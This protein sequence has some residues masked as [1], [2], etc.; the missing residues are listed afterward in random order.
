VLERGVPKQVDP[1]QRRLLV[2]DA[3]LD[4]ILE[5]GIHSVTLARIAERTGLAVGSI[6][7]FF[8]GFDEVL[9]FTFAVL[10]TRMRERAADVGPAGA[11]GSADPL[12]TVGALLLRSAPGQ[13]PHREN[14]AYLEYLTRARTIPQLRAEIARTQAASEEVVG[15]LL[16][17]A[18]AGTAA[19]EADVR[20]ETAAVSALLNGLALTDAHAAEPLDPA[21]VREIVSRTLDRLRRAYPLLGP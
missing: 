21:D 4:E 14:V 6:R 19:T 1:E 20:L 18:L 17:A 2:A 15:E 11:D 9:A 10:V 8:T 12:D 13:V 5:R 16:R 7:H 3:V